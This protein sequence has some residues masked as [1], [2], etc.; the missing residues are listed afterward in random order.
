MLVALLPG[1][2]AP[3]HGCVHLHAKP[4]LGQLHT[5]LHTCTPDRVQLYNAL[6]TALHTSVKC[7]GKH[8]LPCG[9]RV[10]PE[11]HPWLR[12]HATLSMWLC[13]A[14][15]ADTPA[16]LLREGLLQL[17][18]TSQQGM[19]APA[20]LA[21]LK[22]PAEQ[23]ARWGRSTCACSSSIMQALLGAAWLG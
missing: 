16:E 17:L 21:H 18:R 12:R 20:M 23:Q 5:S 7:I 11:V 19:T 1:K 9:S 2:L 22:L 15:S 13:S 8:S 10:Q 6:H 4:V 14:G 3:Q